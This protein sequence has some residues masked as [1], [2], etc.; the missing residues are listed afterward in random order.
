ML[1]GVVIQ[2]RIGGEGV[3]TVP[4]YKWLFKDVLLW[5]TPNK[6]GEEASGAAFLH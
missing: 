6:T 4:P 5:E 1:L 2:P 3:E